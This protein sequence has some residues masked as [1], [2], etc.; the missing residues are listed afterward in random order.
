[1]LDTPE[2]RR[3]LRLLSAAFRERDEDRAAELIRQSGE[4]LVDGIRQSWGEGL[5]AAEILHDRAERTLDEA[6]ATDDPGKRQA[7]MQRFEMYLA[8]ARE[9]AGL[10]PTI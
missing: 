8:A 3:C 5:R 10:P 2:F 7:L 1:M 9:S 6:D 4:A